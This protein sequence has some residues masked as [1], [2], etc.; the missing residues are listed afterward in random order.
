[1]RFRLSGTSGERDV[2]IEWSDG[3]LHGPSEVVERVRARAEGLEGAPV[4]PPEGGTQPYST[5]EHLANP[6]SARVLIEREL[7]GGRSELEVL[8]GEFPPAPRFRDRL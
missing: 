4:G 8:E 6:H 1:M 7:D 5:S 2:Q 3:E